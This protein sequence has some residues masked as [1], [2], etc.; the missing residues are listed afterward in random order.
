MNDHNIIRRSS[1]KNKEILENN[2]IIL[3]TKKIS[4]K[5]EFVLKK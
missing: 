2:K 1:T 3:D 5:Q 4:N